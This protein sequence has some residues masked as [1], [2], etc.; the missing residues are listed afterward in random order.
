M[1]NFKKFRC[2]VAFAGNTSLLIGLALI[3]PT[4]EF[5]FIKVLWYSLLIFTAVQSIF[6]LWK[7]FSDE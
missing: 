2:L 4:S 3:L 5:N 6:S 1:M 7:D